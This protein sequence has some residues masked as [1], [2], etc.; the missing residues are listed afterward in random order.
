MT[1]AKE[2]A[3][4]LRKLATGRTEWRVQD[5]VSKCYCIA[6]DH[7]QWINPERHAREW[8]ANHQRRFPDHQHSKYEVAEARWFSELEQAALDAADAL[9]ADN[10]GAVPQRQSEEK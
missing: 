6:Y 3:A 5:P 9:S 2:L 8:L 1:D 7:Y 4:R 10:G